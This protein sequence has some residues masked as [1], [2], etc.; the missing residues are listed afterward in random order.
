M[1]E[2]LD[3]NELIQMSSNARNT[4]KESFNTEDMAN[5]FCALIRKVNEENIN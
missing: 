2:S 4:V 5:R 3:K 1:I